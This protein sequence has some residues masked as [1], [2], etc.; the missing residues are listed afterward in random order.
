MIPLFHINQNLS[1]DLEYW[2]V[3]VTLP[4]AT[5]NNKYTVVLKGGVL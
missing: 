4:H 2:S 1:Y 3:L 5:E